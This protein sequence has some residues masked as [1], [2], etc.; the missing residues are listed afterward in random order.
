MNFDY[1]KKKIEFYSL[2]TTSIT[3]TQTT[4]PLV[5]WAHAADA[6]VKMPTLAHWKATETFFVIA[7]QDG[8]AIDALVCL[9]FIHLASILTSTQ[10]FSSIK[11][12]DSPF[13]F[14]HFPN[15]SFYFINFINLFLF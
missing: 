13:N 3:V 11:S 1:A 15:Y 14:Y 2:A 4:V 7:I 6:H 10:Q 5:F 9:I 8:L 12:I